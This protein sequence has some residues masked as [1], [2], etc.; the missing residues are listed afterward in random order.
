MKKCKRC[1]EKKPLT[2]FAFDGRFKKAKRR[3]AVCLACSTHQTDNSESDIKDY[4]RFLPWEKN[5]EILMRLKRVGD[6]MNEGIRKPFL[7]Q[8][9]MM[10][11]DPTYTWDMAKDDMDRVE[12]MILRDTAGTLA[13]KRANSIARIM[14]TLAKAWDEFYKSKDPKLKVKSFEIILD[15]EKEIISLEGTRAPTQFNVTAIPLSLEA[16]LAMKELEALGVSPHA[17]YQEFEAFVV[18]FAKQKQTLVIE[19]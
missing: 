12:Q 7:I 19:G 11:Q 4:D 15:L 17:L 2:D 14:H 16:Q 9:H 3:V 18:D 6:L 5:P 13:Q 10:Q 1:G 8:R